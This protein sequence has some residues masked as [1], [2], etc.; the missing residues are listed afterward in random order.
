MQKVGI[1][2]ASGY[3]GEVLVALLSQHPQ[4]GELVLASSTH[5]GERID[6]VLPR[7]AGLA[8]GERFT[9]ADRESLRAVAADVWFL[10]LPHGVAAEYAIPLVESGSRVIDLSADFRLESVEVYERY[11]GKRP[12]HAEWLGRAPYVL[13][14][15]TEGDWRN[16]ALIAC[17]GCYPTSVLLPLWP[18]LKAGLIT[19]DGIVIHSM[20]GIS[21]AGKKSTLEYAFCERSESLKAYGLGTHR[22]LSEIEE[23][24]EKAAGRP[25]TVQFT[26][27]LVPMVRGLATTIVTP[28]EAGLS[29]VAEI[30]E[31]AFAGR[32]AVRLLQAGETPDTRNVVGRNLA[33]LAVYKD[34]R[35]QNVVI[36][37]AI[38]NLVKGAGGQAVQIWNMVNGWPELTG[39][40]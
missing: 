40:L 4:V 13:P 29:A 2:G 31:R 11:Y 16:A 19:G 32:P 30:W 24:L 17:P 33:H 22:H 21:G 1:L 35:T 34:D 3:S 36:T 7:L 10:A 26:P 5:A 18:L 37:S 12:L 23:Q 28:C 20:S 25:V 39:L 38:D 27:H 8:K 6:A 15:L 14:E 9:G